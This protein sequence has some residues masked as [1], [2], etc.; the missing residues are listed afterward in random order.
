MLTKTSRPRGR[1][2]RVRHDWWS[3]LLWPGT[4]A[5]VTVEQALRQEDRER[6]YLPAASRSHTIH[7]ERS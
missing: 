3:E 7:R 1:H 2:R 6:T 4:V 5:A